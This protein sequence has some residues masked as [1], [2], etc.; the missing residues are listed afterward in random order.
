MGEV[1]V[2]LQQVS[3]GLEPE[4]FEELYSHDLSDDRVVVEE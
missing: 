4:Q 3:T 2:A 1:G